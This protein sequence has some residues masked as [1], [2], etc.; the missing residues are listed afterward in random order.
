MES[1]PEIT[2]DLEKQFPF[3]I[4][5]LS[6]YSLYSSLIDFLQN[7]INN[8]ETKGTKIQTLAVG[9]ISFPICI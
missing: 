2:H 7:V 4:F 8:Y 6:V 1:I 5:P 9:E 3:K